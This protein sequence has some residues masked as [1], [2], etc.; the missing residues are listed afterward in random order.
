M[1]NSAMVQGSSGV[2]RVGEVGHADKP[3]QTGDKGN[4]EA[5]ILVESGAFSIPVESHQHIIGR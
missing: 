1:N 2:F 4:L 5:G 3:G